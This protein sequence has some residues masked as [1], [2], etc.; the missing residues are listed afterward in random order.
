MDIGHDDDIIL[1]FMRLVD[2][3][4]GIIGVSQRLQ[5]ALFTLGSLLNQI[6]IL[7]IYIYIYTVLPPPPPLFFV[8]PTI[9]SLI[10]Q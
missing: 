3:I 5:T 6:S 10:Y 9:A 1:H 4:T 7:D 2:V 8:Q